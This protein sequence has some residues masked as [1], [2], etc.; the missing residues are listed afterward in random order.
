MRHDEVK[1]CMEVMVNIG[2]DYANR[3]RWER[4]TVL[5][6]YP[7]GIILV[8]LPLG[9]PDMMPQSLHMTATFLEP[10]K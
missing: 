2:L 3:E 10:I 4:G 8:S 7:D 6:V 1:E 5:R 9:F